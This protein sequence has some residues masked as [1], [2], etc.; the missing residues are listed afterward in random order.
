MKKHAATPQGNDGIA[1]VGAAQVSLPPVLTQSQASL[2]YLQPE[3]R[4]AHQ[5]ETEGSF[6][7]QLLIR[8]L[9]IRNLAYAHPHGKT[10]AVGCDDGFTVTTRQ[11]S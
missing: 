5:R 3:K 1:Q 9:L 7:R 11:K 8:Q 4:E 10:L 6:K 2:V